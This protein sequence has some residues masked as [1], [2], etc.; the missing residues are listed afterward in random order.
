MDSAFT[1]H[2]TDVANRTV[3][4]FRTV[5]GASVAQQSFVANNNLVSPVGIALD[6]NGN[7][8]VADPDAMNL[9]GAIFGSDSQDPIV[10]GG[11]NY[12]NPR[13]LTIITR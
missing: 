7:P 8:Y 3:H 6:G 12:V 2:V 5:P 13:G 11:G 4:S 9:A 1:V 10:T